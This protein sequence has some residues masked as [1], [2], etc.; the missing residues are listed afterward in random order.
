[1]KAEKKETKAE[2]KA[3]QKPEKITH[4]VKKGDTLRAI[5]AKYLGKASRANEIAS[6]NKLATDILKVGRVLVIPKK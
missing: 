4:T 6:V 5:A 1:M 2:I 3:E